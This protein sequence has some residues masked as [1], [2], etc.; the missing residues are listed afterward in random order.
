MLFKVEQFISCSCFH[1]KYIKFDAN[2]PFSDK[3]L[4]E[5][6]VKGR[7]NQMEEALFYT[8]N[9]EAKTVTEDEEGRVE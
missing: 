6:S 4:R 2:K 7:S 8:N 1:T 3:R 9:Q 5:V